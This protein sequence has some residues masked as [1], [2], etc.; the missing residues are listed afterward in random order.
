MTVKT[1]KK[2]VKWEIS[3]D[4]YIELLEMVDKNAKSILTLS[5]D[6]KRLKIRIG[7]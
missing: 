4:D 7:I 5:N 6:V 1:K 3:Q 2:P